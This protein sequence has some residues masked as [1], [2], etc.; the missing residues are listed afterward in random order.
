M[1][2][3]YFFQVELDRRYNGTTFARV[4]AYKRKK[5]T[6]AHDAS[7]ADFAAAL[8]ALPTLGSVSVSRFGPTTL[9]EFT[10]SVT[11][12]AHPGGLGTCA[13]RPAACLGVHASTPTAVTVAGA[14]C[15]HV[16]G[17]YVDDHATLDGRMVGRV[18]LVVLFVG[19]WVF[20]LGREHV[21][22][23]RARR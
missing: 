7:A 8:A 18:M 21:P 13:D 23:V 17:T 20:A 2:L 19:L 6:V 3:F 10:W 22:V 1:F 16:N 12:T 5:A 11:F 9:N 14:G 15:R 4:T